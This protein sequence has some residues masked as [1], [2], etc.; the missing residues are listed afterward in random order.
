MFPS[1]VST[2]GIHCVKQRGAKSKRLCHKQGSRMWGN[3]SFAACHKNG[4]IVSVGF[5]P[6]REGMHCVFNGKE[7]I[8]L[9][10]KNQEQL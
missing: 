9:K 3:K 2:A 4:V 8:S 7:N 6:H 5:P 1:R 10:W